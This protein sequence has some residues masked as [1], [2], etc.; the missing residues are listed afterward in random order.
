MEIAAPVLSIVIPCY[1]E[2]EV[3]PE[4]VSRLT[5]LLQRDIADNKI[6]SDS[7]MLLVDDG[8]NDGTWHLISELGKVNLHIK[9]LRLAHNRGHQFAL[10]AGLENANGDAIVSIDADLQDDIS[11]ISTMIEAYKKGNDIVYGVRASRKTDTFFKR[12]TAQGYYWLLKKLGVDIVYNHADFRLMSRKTIEAL[13]NY[14]EVNLFLRGIIPTL[15]FRTTQVTYT[16]SERFAGESKYPLK[17]MLSLAL[18]GVTSFSIAPLRL[19]SGLGFAIFVISMMVS[20]WAVYTYL[21]TDDAIP[22]WTSSVLPMYLLGGVQLLSLGMIGEYVAKTYM[23]TKRR[24]R[25]LIMNE[26]NSDH[27]GD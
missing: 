5:E 11:V 23:E 17:K 21:M 4:T 20:M 25:Y 3:L 14:G 16:R 15:G 2:E 19:I 7:H 22:G 10:L 13:K 1:N 27:S 18:E 6:A 24:P 8:S 12:N 26:V 9:G